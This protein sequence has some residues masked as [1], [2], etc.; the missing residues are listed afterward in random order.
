MVERFEGGAPAVTENRV[1]RGSAVVLGFEASLGCW[2]PGDAWL[3]AWLVKH[4]LGKVRPSYACKGGIAYRLASP[5][6]DH[7]FL[8][9]D[10]PV[11]RR[12]RLD[13]RG[14]RYRRWED[15]VEGKAVSSI[16]SI[17]VPPDG[18]RWL[19]AVK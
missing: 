12:L 15:P 6:A 11:V 5:T 4:A 10:E 19:R 1:G 17:A 9:N 16:A 3:Q 13:V 14:R 18:A 8:I 7:Y 2:K